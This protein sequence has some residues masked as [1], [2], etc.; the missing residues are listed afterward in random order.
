MSVPCY[1]PNSDTGTACMVCMCGPQLEL[2]FDN[3]QIV[4][5]SYF[6]PV[7]NFPYIR[8]AAIDQALVRL[9]EQ[10]SSAS[11]SIALLEYR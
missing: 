4:G 5:A 11:T 6:V 2:H 10:A 3:G 1:I 8:I 9:P 7:H